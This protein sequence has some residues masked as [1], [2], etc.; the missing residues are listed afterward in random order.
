MTTIYTPRQE[1]D[2]QGTDLTGLDG[3]SNRTYTLK[4]LP[5]A[6]NI[7]VVV[8]N[9][10]YTRDVDYTFNGTTIIFLNSM[11]D[12]MTIQLDYYTPTILVG[13]SQSGI[14]KYCSV[15]GLASYLGVLQQIPNKDSPTRAELGTGTGTLTEFWFSDEG[16]IEGTY[17]IS[18]GANYTNLVETT[19]YIIDLQY[20][21]I[22]LTSVGL[23]KVGND[24]IYAQYKFFGINSGLTNYEAQKALIAAE[25]QITN[26]TNTVF[27]DYTEDDPKYKKVLNEEHHGNSPSMSDWKN[28]G[29]VFDVAYPPFMRLETTVNGTYTTGASTIT[30]T[31]AQGFPNA[32]TINIG[33]NK[34]A[35]T[36]R[37]GNVLTIPITTPSIADGALVHG[38]V[39]EIS[40]TPEG[41]EPSYDVATPEQD[42]TI[43]YVQGR[44]LLLSNAYWNQN[45]THAEDTVYPTRYMIRFSYMNA[46]YEA[47][48]LP[49]IPAEIEQVAYTIAA[50]SMYP[51]LKA[52]SYLKANQKF[53]LQSNRE[54]QDYIRNT[55]INYKPLNVGT[56]PYN[57]SRLS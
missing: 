34:V 10:P 23:A 3:E 19:D 57:R 15:E 41:R 20:S 46:W 4:Y 38:E 1:S 24:K 55:L 52:R 32:A 22:I 42:Y 43:D 5:A 53:E 49:Y 8:S 50:Q 26:I 18:Y 25:N 30:L 11:L 37:T 35:Y 29:K 51:R 45:V 17:T 14:L 27:A 12:S 28:R 7:Q 36:S 40:F 56:S 33:D 31:N 21:K 2:V 39:I 48:E 9:I 47:G 44:I 6:D 54:T 13:S 16:I